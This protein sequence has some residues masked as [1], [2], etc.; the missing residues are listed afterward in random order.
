MQIQ[1]GVSAPIFQ[2]PQSHSEDQKQSLNDVI[3]QYDPSDLSDEEAKT[4]VNEIS[5]LGISRGEDLTTALSEAG[6]DPKGLADQAGFGR[7]DGPPPPPPSV[8]GLGNK[9]A[10]SD[11]VQALLSI[12]NELRVNIEENGVEGDFS[13]LLTAALEDAGIDTTTPIVDFRA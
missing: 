8:S 2:S 7:G 5:E 9:G 13:E 1:S 6:F 11:E 4:L 10:E 12:V 3:A